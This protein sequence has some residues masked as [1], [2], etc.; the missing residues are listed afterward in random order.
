MNTNLT[1]LLPDS[2]TRRIRHGYL[3]RLLTVALLLGTFVMI[4]HGLLLLPSH[5]HASAEVRERTEE[6]ARLAI[7][8]ATPEE[9]AAQA[10]IDALQE[11]ISY[12]SRFGQIPT[13]SRV[14]ETV[15]LVPSDGIGVQGIAYTAPVSATSTG[16]MVLSGIATT[17]E[18][19]RSYV[20]ALEG[21]PGVAEVELPISAYAK[22]SSI[23]FSITL[24]GTFKP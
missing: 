13:A 15:V 12:L 20:G 19:L 22:E 8:A 11:D 3:L 23:P 24:T 5:L 7:E 14:L 4:V 9:R 21:I 2:K 1:N 10:R 18:S 6:R 17:R 16:R